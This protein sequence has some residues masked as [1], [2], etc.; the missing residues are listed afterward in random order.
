M[1][2]TLRSLL[3]LAVFALPLST[4]AENAP[5]TIQ[6]KALSHMMANKMVVA[7]LDECT[8]RGF[9]V[10]AAVV[11]RNGDLFAFLRN[12]LAGPHTEEVSQRK[13]YSAATF[14]TSTQQMQARTDL[15]FAPGILL[16]RGGVP[17]NIGGVFYGGIAVAGASPEVDELCAEA[18]IAA[19]KEEIL[20][21]S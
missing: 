21:D 15:S 18:G 12:P 4:F 20:F 19:V 10:A 16:I 1:S 13:A 9:S 7:S 14:Q 11:G 2:N 3:S 5:A 6:L 8:K 17:V